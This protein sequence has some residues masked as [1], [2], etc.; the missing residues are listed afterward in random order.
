MTTEE[1]SIFG[2]CCTGSEVTVRHPTSR[3]A[4][5]T[6]I[7][8]T[9]CLMNVSVMERMRMAPTRLAKGIAGDGDQ[10]RFAQLEGTGRR[11]ALPG[12]ETAEN[13]HLVADHRPA[14]HGLFMHPCV[15]SRVGFHDEDV[16]AARSLAQGADGNRDDGR[17]RAHRDLDSHRRA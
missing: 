9:G 7:A 16:I 2:Y 11:D 4:R 1:L 8:R 12:C 14:L 6:T 15:A 13:E 3:I 5:F 17:R 10:H